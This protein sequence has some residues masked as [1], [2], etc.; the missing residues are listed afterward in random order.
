MANTLYIAATEPRSGK[1]AVSLGIMELLLANVRRVAFFRPVIN[2]TDQAKAEIDNDINLINGHFHLNIPYTSMYA[3]TSSQV[4]E[5]LSRGRREEIIEGILHKYNTLASDYDFVL[6]EG[7]EFEGATASFDFEINA[8]IC[9]NLACPVL[10]VA[11]AHN[12]EDSEV[13]HSI[14]VYHKFLAKYGC[15]VV[16]TIVNRVEPG[17]HETFKKLLYTE[18]A[19]ENEL[20][21]TIQN[22]E[23]LGNPTVAEIVHLL[24][25]RVLQGEERLNRHVRSIAVAAGELRHL[26]PQLEYGTL[27]VTSGDRVDIILGC[28]AAL[29][30]RSMPNIAGLL[31]SEGL[32]PEKVIFKL[33]EGFRYPVP[34]LGTGESTFKAARL[35]DTAHAVITPGNTRKITQALAVFEQNID[36]T[37]LARKIIHTQTTVLTPKRFEYTLLQQARSAKQ[38]IVLPEGEE[39]R[40]LQA[41]EILKRR[42]IVDLTLLGNPERI[43]EKAALLGLHL[44]GIRVINPSASPDLEDYAHTFYELRKHKGINL[45]IAYDMMNDW[46]YFGTMMVYTGASDGMV[47]GAIHTTGDTIRPAFQF[48]KTRAGCSLVSSVFLMCLK[49]RV[50]VYSDCAI[51]PDPDAPQLAQIALSSAFTART[52]GITPR[53]AMLSYSTG[54][55]GSGEAVE[56]V[57]EATRLARGLAEKRYPGLQI[58][59]PI[60]YDA[61]IDSTVARVKMPGSEVA[62]QATVFVFP[63]LNTGNNTYK[64]VQRSS[65][66]VAIGPILQGLKKPVNDLSRGCLVPDIVN[67]V[68]I[69]AIQAQAAGKNEG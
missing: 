61:A 53:V 52:F 34:L 27:V 2:T 48:I 42:D 15:T 31:L 44:D 32:I 50:L 23:N 16:A 45:D 36:T 41:A 20:I 14:N 5:L 54:T 24:H 30:S 65:G 33:I 60:Q 55:S 51:N 38:H 18:R 69:T 7:Y 66:A 58:D 35:L 21:Y 17:R 4:K 28:L 25:A 67:T 11:N 8:D 49:D 3:Y 56:K 12:R 26:L 13:V 43:F 37:R 9:N 47:S 46:N 57:R 62:G 64:A 10:L 6:C 39:E 63:D 22:E 29:A 68:A 40:I 59:G 19:D 1:S